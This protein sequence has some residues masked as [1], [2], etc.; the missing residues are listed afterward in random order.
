MGRAR[1]IAVN[2]VDLPALGYPTNPTSAMMRNSNRKFPSSLGSPGWANRGVC[3]LAVAKFR[4]PNPPRPPFA[5]RKTLPIGG[6]IHH[7]LAFELGCLVRGTVVL[8][9]KVNFQGPFVAGTPHLRPGDYDRGRRLRLFV[10]IRIGS[11]LRGRG[12]GGKPPNERSDGNFNDQVLPGMPIHAFS[13]PGMA[14]LRNQ[15]RLVKLRDQVIEV[16][17]GLKNHVSPTPAVAAAGAA[18]GTIGLAMK[19]HTAFAAVTGARVN[20][21]LIDEH[22]L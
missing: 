18:L 9:G 10:R 8:L 5:E 1:E 16:V 19:G 14:F 12:W 4:F 3:R 20:F 15:P 17:I 22:N 13:Q 7:Q 2:S 11:G 6:H 21:Y